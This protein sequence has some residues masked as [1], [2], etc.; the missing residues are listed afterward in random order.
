M[1]RIDK[2]ILLVVLLHLRVAFCIDCD[3]QFWPQ[4]SRSKQLPQA[5]S[6]SSPNTPNTPQQPVLQSGETMLFVVNCS[7]CNQPA[8]VIKQVSPDGQPRGNLFYRFFS[9]NRYS[10]IV[11][12]SP[13]VDPV[14]RSRFEST[15]DM[16][17]KY[18]ECKH[19]PLCAI[20]YTPV[21]PELA[22]IHF[23]VEANL[24]GRSDIR[25]ELV[26]INSTPTE[27][28]DDIPIPS[29][30]S[31]KELRKKTANK[32]R[33]F[34]I[35]LVAQGVIPG[36]NATASHVTIF[37]KP[38][39]FY[40]VFDWAVFFIA[41]T[42]SLSAGCS[43]DPRAFRKQLKRALPIGIGLVVHL[44]V[45]PL[46]GLAAGYASSLPPEKAYGLFVTT[47]LQVGGATVVVISISDC[48]KQF[49]L[50]LAQIANVL[51][52]ATSP[53]WIYVVGTYLF[54]QPIFLLRFCGLISLVALVQILG[55]GLRCIR[56][57]LARAVL[58]W[59][60][61]PFL[62]LSAILFITLGVY[63]NQYVFHAPQPMAY[64]Q[65]VGLAL[66]LMVTTSYTC[67]W[68]IG[69]ILH[70]SVLRSRAIANQL[71]VYQG[72]LAIPLLRI[73]IPSPEGELASAIAL[74]TVFLTPVPLVYNAVLKV[75]EVVFTMST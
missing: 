6:K 57:A 44:L 61:H 33:Q 74:W 64:L 15:G 42:I 55:F 20:L 40:T 54:R 7:C 59:F 67:G 28:P 47:T 72:F 58:T 51:N 5:Y 11:S 48:H 50:A 49:A 73:C 45:T 12:R 30:L 37:L 62:L 35:T 41:C 21:T 19:F 8:E 43:T 10:T 17:T 56:P 39:I 22:N 16:S 60:S 75:C 71:S 46:I 34:E 68:L 70:L 69:H 32:R 13:N 18:E 53:L 23:W 2:P 36:G 27:Q 25:V 9:E 65:H 24:L 26:W 63:I 31:E 1:L 3:L 14:I 38:Q 66:F 52:L 29:A 4:L